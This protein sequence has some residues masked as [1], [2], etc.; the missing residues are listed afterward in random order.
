M[1]ICDFITAEANQLFEY[2]KKVEE[3]LYSH[4]KY[5]WLPR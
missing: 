4:K 1:L 3:Y 2:Y 5:A